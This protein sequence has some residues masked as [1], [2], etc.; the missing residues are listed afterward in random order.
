VILDEVAL[1]CLVALAEI[2]SAYGGNIPPGHDDKAAVCLE[3]G[4]AADELEL[5]VSVA[6]SVALEES[7][8]TRSLKSKAGA[9]GP[10]Q[11]I[12][13]YHCPDA[14]GEH[15]PH[16]RKG[17]LAGCDLIVDGLKALRWFWL[18]YGEGDWSLGLAHYNSGEKV[19]ASSRAY[20]RRIMKRA[21]RMDEQVG[22]IMEAQANAR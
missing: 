9:M 7:R 16:A 12:P 22:A 21:N 19:Y 8:F 5:P 18:E 3:V 17:Q 6:V 1:I 14:M 10:L 15:K 20:A 11:I 2:V 13:R 4:R